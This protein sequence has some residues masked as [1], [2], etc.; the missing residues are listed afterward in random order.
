VK[1]RSTIL[2]LRRSRKNMI[3]D[4]CYPEQAKA[5]LVQGTNPAEMAEQEEQE[6]IIDPVINQRL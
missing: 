1:N 4:Y 2:G 3:N 5:I 6:E